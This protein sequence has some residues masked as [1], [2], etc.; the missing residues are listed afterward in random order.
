MDAVARAKRLVSHAKALM[1]GVKLGREALRVQRQSMRAAVA[2]ARTLRTASP[3]DLV[4]LD[5]AVSAIFRRV[6]QGRMNIG[7]PGRSTAHLDALA[8]LIAEHA[9]IYT[10]KRDGDSVR[11][12]AKEELVGGLFQGGARTLAFVDGRATITELAVSAKTIDAIVTTLIAVSR[13]PGL[14]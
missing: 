11:V 10:Y 3:H 13:A 2:Q 14:T 1:E 12:L 7:T 9:P 4:P 5:L 8:Y 6:Y